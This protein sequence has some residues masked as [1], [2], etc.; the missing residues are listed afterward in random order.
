VASET[1]I[2]NMSLRMLGLNAISDINEKKRQEAR[3]CKIY[4][5]TSR[6]FVLGDA[7]WP[8]ATTMRELSPSEM[9]ENFN[10][11]FRYAF[12]YPVKAARLNSLSKKGEYDTIHYDTVLSPDGVRLVLA[13]E[14]CVVAR[15]N[16]NITDPSAFSAHFALAVVYHL[17]SFLAV[18][19]RGNQQMQQ[20]NIQLYAGVRALAFR[21][22][23]RETNRERAKKSNW[24]EARTKL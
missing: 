17:A 21:Q 16:L 18:S 7:P 3:D 13:D 20:T 11:E 1:G 15:Y 9:P 4:Y 14:Q 2:C 12:V 24:I 23:Q 19:L 10:A 5:S 8:F 6:D 22:A